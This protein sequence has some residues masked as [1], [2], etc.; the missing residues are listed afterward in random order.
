MQYIVTIDA[1]HEVM[2]QTELNHRMYAFFADFLF[3]V[4]GRSFA[5]TVISSPACILH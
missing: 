5:N 4:I 2:C 1:L 3:S